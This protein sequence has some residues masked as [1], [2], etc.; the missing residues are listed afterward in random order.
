MSSFS[1][2]GS[3][4][5]VNGTTAGLQFAS[6][7]AGLSGGGFVV[8][9]TTTSGSGNKLLGQ[10]YDANGAAVGGEL[11][12]SN[13]GVSNAADVTALGTGFVVAYEAPNPPLFHPNSVWTEVFDSA[14]AGSG[15]VEAETGN[16]QGHNAMIAAS[17]AGG[18]LTVW[19]ESGIGP[20][21]DQGAIRGGVSG[22]TGLTVNTTTAGNQGG[23]SVAALLDGSGNYVA[24]WTE[25]DGVGN[26]EMK[27]QFLSSGGAKLGAEF[28]IDNDVTG[29]SGLDMEIAG[30]PGAGY[31]I[32]FT[33]GF[34][35]HIKVFGAGNALLADF[36]ANPGVFAQSEDEAAIAVLSNGLLAV[37][38]RDFSSGG[39][40]H[41][42]VFAP[43]GTQIGTEVLLQAGSGSGIITDPSIAALAN[44][45]FVVSW[46]DN[47]ATLGD[48][49]HGITAQRFSTG[50][51]SI[52][53][54]TAGDD[55]LDG[56]AQVGFFMGYVGFD[57][58]SYAAAAGPVTVNLAN[59]ALNAGAAAGDEIG[60]SVERIVGS[61]FGDTLIG[62]G[63][64]NILHGGSGNDTIDGA[65]GDDTISGGA[66][67]DTLTGGTGIDLADYSAATSPVT[68]SLALAGAQNTGATTGS[69]TLSGFEN[70]LGAAFADTLTGDGQ[71]NLLSGAGGN[72]TL[73]G[74]GGNDTLDG[75]LGADTLNGGADN[76]TFIVDDAGDVLAEALNQGTDTVNTALSSYS[77]FSIVNVERILFTGAGNF[78]G[79]GNG[80]DNRIEGGAGNDR[81]VVDQGGADRYFGGT[82]VSDA[83]DYRPSAVGA[84]VNLTTNIHGGAAAGDVFSSIEYFYGSNTAG[85]TLTGA[86]F[87]DR[88]DGY[89]GNDVLSGLGGSDTLNG[90][91]GDD[92]IAGGALIDFLTGN[93]GA[94]DFN[95]GNVSE[96][97]PSSGARD[98]I[99]DFEAGIDDI[100][101][102]AIDAMASTGADD[103]FTQ[104]I[105]AAAFTAEGQIR[106]YQSGANT[107]IEFN[108]TGTTGAEMQIQLQNFTAAALTIADF[109]A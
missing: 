6:S 18:F 1:S 57:T 13:V 84:I 98:R 69:D 52:V 109:I 41:L 62:D 107:I 17:T 94:D 75:G 51:P 72:D 16:N 34:K 63:R 65:G 71:A 100:D 36:E 27:G 45:Q 91:D 2:L 7:V 88:F 92:E 77:L 26:N 19:E 47:R 53:D 24:A 102:S 28:T 10:I 67:N 60:N 90:G 12:I 46:T 78:V 64:A 58:L 105:G 101:V 96:S 73:N 81:F 70:L 74:N 5:R 43:D 89:G 79:R 11:T 55:T 93:A 108:T 31:A 4:F 97:G 66:D 8:V 29:P 14:G 99:Y 76:D 103:A 35:T 86:G 37:A 85:D 48:P 54:G 83:V 50:A 82:G 42:R 21:T 56:A 23:P 39:F 9:Y 22:G 49:D 59:P 3:E 38:G 95:Y 30:R 80:L 40:S 104:F 61:G 68:V 87:N 25:S 20:D 106:A 32:A 33:D 44:G 15:A